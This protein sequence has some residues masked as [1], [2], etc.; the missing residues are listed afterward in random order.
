M[1]TPLGVGVWYRRFRLAAY[2]NVVGSLVWTVAIILPFPPFSY[3]QPIIVGGG[4]GL[5]FLVGYVLYVAVGGCG[6]GWLS[7]TLHTIE[8]GEN[9]SLNAPLM[10]LGSVSL[11]LGITASCVLLG[12]AGALGG[13]ASTLNDASTQTVRELLLPYVLPISLAT[14][15]AVAGCALALLAMV[16]A[17]GL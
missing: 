8:I 17:R 11:E 10:W 12:L 15:L 4:A 3:L 7:G 2:V 14:L 13:Y 9:R 16:R 6:F 5:W 1:P